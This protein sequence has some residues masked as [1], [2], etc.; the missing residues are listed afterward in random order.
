MPGGGLIQ[1]VA[2]GASDYTTFHSIDIDT[3]RAY[4]QRDQVLFWYVDRED[5]FATK[6]DLDTDT[7]FDQNILTHVPLDMRPPLNTLVPLKVRE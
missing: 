6:E 5:G 4:N 2:L 1:L 3:C 7:P